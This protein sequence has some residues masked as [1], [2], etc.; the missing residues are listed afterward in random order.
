M[1]RA[2]I[3]LLV[4][5]GALL[6]TAVLS[7][8]VG[9][10]A[11][12]GISQFFSLLSNSGERTLQELVM[13]DIRMPRTVVAILTGINLAIA[14]VILQAITR[15]ALASPSILGINQGAALGMTLAVLLPSVFVVGVEAMAIIGALLAGTLTF[16]FSGGFRGSIRPLPLV[17]SG[18]AVGAFSF[19]MV[20]FTFTLDD[21]VAR[22]V[23]LWTTGDI[24]GVRWH[25]TTAL[26]LW[27][28]GGI[29]AAMLIAHK[30]NLL[31]MG[32]AAAQGVGADPRKTLLIGAV[33]AAGLTGVSVATA[34]PM[35][36][37]GLVVPHLCRI[38]VGADHRR[39]LP[40]AAVG[41]AVL[42]LFADGLSKL[43]VAPEEVPVGV[44]AA[45]IGAPYFVY[46][47]LFSKELDL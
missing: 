38:V 41:G 42:L 20:R 40:A 37:V 32:E 28:F 15:N 7:L 47:A 44:I 22:D 1:A 16:G 12:V 10:R 46:Q 29:L 36:F 45:L 43:V 9:G 11:D 17:L 19:A 25:D 21:E 39:L 4:L 31:A 6:A 23:I 8:H 14:G 33:I 3:K 35:A 24:S 13:L 18:V 34:G 26:S 27:A 30:L 5:L 2:S